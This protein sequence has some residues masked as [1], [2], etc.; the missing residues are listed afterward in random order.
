MDPELLIR[1][2]PRVYYMAH[3][4]AWP[5]IH[6]H[7]LLST[8]A[9]L[10]LFEINGERRETL[11][12][13]RRPET[14]VIEHPVHGK[15][16]LRDNKPMDDNG[17]Y[18]A[19]AGMQPTEWY[20]LLNQKVFFWLSEER[21]TTLR[22]AAAYREEDHCVLTVDTNSLVKLHSDRIW[23][24]LMKSGCTKPHPH[25]RNREIFRRILDYPFESWR[26][27]KGGA[28]KAVVELAVDHSVPDIIEFLELVTIRNRDVRG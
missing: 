9:L 12:S 15:A 7:G 20:K 5:R 25:P 16:A 27:T 2:F 8:S 18:R 14:V 13:C 4:D 10:D 23:L 19:L 1:T 6:R 3:V 28:Q 22:S 26:K 17:L 11:E 24:C 21:L